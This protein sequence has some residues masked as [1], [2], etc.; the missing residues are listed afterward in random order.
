MLVHHSFLIQDGEEEQ[1]EG[2]PDP[3][4]VVTAEVEEDEEVDEETV[5]ETTPE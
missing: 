1:H 4:T 2:S 3:E 5:Q